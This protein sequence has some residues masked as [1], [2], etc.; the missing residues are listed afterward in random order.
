MSMSDWRNH[1]AIKWAE[2]E[3]D[4]I[5]NLPD[6]LAAITEEYAMT[7]TETTTEEIE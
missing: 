1:M 4:A 3:E 2:I 5:D 6:T 7:G